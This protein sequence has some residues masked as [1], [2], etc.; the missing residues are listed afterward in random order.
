[1]ALII[2]LDL[3]L[4]ASPGCHPGAS[5]FHEFSPYS[6]SSDMCAPLRPPLSIRAL[7]P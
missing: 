3:F 6:M 4:T 5:S 2:S 7:G 1:M